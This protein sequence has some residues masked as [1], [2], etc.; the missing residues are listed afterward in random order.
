MKRYATF[1]HSTPPLT[2]GT[3]GLKKS[4]SSQQVDNVGNSS[5]PLE[6]HGDDGDSLLNKA[7]DNPHGPTFVTK[8][9]NALASFWQELFVN[10]KVIETSTLGT[11]DLAHE[12]NNFIR[13]TLYNKRKGFFKSSNKKKCANDDKTETER[14]TRAYQELK[15]LEWSNGVDLDMVRKRI[16]TAKGH[17][18][19]DLALAAHDWLAQTKSADACMLQ[20]KGHAAVVVGKLPDHPLPKDMTKWPAHLSICDPWLNVACM[21]QNYPT[22]FR[23]KMQKWSDDQKLIH[24]NGNWIS[25]ND[26]IWMNLIDDQKSLW[27]PDNFINPDLKEPLRE[28][29]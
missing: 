10:A 3:S 23:E 24:A 26:P 7:A 19:D 12:A 29:N 8:K 9:D 20:M 2:Q 22:R 28:C 14:I 21:A 27:H 25:P 13:D 6:F 11:L 4:R 17:N 5:L 1:N 16:W 18:C 15:L